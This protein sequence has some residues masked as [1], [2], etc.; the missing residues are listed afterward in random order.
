MPAAEIKENFMA[1][2]N[3]VIE[4]LNRNAA[5]EG[6]GQPAPGDDLFEK[7]VIDS[8]TLVEFVTL[9]EEQFGIKIPDSDISPDN[10]RT[11]QSIERYVE[12][13]RQ[14]V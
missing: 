14:T 10:F 11:I 9:L 3:E 2:K 4:Y 12:K 1:L 13:K 5:R 6:V 7:G 8:F